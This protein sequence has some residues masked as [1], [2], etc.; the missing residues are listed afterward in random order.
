MYISE[1]IKLPPI[2]LMHSEYDP[3]VS[4]ANSRILYEKLVASHHNVF[5]YE[6]ENDAHGGAIY[7][8]NAIL[9]IVQEFCKKCVSHQRSVCM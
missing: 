1:N 6:L 9:D 2:L 5:Y 3:I 7:Y 8:D 4:V